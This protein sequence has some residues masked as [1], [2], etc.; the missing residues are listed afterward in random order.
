MERIYEKE[1]DFNIAKKQKKV[2]KIWYFIVLGLYVAFAAI[3]FVFYRLEPY[4]SSGIV[5]IKI[6]TYVVTGIF[7][8]FSFVYLGIPMR[9]VRNYYKLLYGIETGTNNEVNG[10]FERYSEEIE[11]RNGIEFKS[12]Y[13]LEYNTKKQEFFERK[14]LF[15]TEKQFPEFTKGENVRY[16]THGN[17]LVEFERI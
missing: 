14:V 5:T 17:V 3:M 7:V 6:I 13:F 8:I 9:R 10:V 11:V 15:D 12:L 4:K 16:Y 1:V 2:L